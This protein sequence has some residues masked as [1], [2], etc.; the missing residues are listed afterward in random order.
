LAEAGYPID[1]EV[2]LA[3]SSL[4]GWKGL[5]TSVKKEL[6]NSLPL[7]FYLL[8]E[9]GVANKGK[10]LGPTASAIL[11]EVF[12]GILMNCKPSFLFSDWSPSDS[13]VGCD[14]ELTLADI[15]KFV[16]V[17]E[18]SKKRATTTKKSKTSKRTTPRKK[19]KRKAR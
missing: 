12:G 2:D 7:F 17:F 14:N 1:C 19:T 6:T 10:R 18:A 3:L 11:L 8:R 15:L 4:G 5:S 9:S 16:D 13:I